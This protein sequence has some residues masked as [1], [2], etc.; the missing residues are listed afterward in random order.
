MEVVNQ[1]ELQLIKERGRLMAMMQHLRMRPKV[2]S[3]SPSSLSPC[4][5]CESNE[6]SGL[7][8]HSWQ[9]LPDV[10]IT[11]PTTTVPNCIVMNGYSSVVNNH[12]KS[13]S[14]ASYDSG[15]TTDTSKRTGNSF[16]GGRDSHCS[17]LPSPPRTPSAVTPIS[18]ATSQLLIVTAPCAQAP[19]KQPHKIVT[20]SKMRIRPKITDR[21]TYPS[22]TAG[23][24]AKT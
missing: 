10:S 9:V 21:T 14:S 11:K 23:L 20:G 19:L 1:L 6:S 8:Q 12:V 24:L 16:G 17:L 13:P 7:A 15:S 3:M 5:P 2:G 22:I 4:D 18:I